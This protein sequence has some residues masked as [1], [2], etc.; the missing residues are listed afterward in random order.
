MTVAVVF[1]LAVEDGLQPV[2]GAAP[3]E[4]LARQLPRLLVAT[5]NGAGDRGVRFLPF[6]GN[7]A[8]K[9]SFLKLQQPLPV[10]TLASLHRQGEV[11]ALVDGQLRQQQLHLRIHDAA[12][13]RPL[14][15]AMLPF[16]PCRPLEVLPRIQFE[17]MSAL[18][19]PGRPPA[20]TTLAGEAQAW[21]LI[22]KDELL[23]LE[24]NLLLNTA[25]DPL[26]A[27][28][29]CVALAG[30]DVD[31]QN[32]VVD[33]SVQLLRHGLQ[34]QGVAALIQ[35]LATLTPDAMPLQQRLAEL[36]QACG[37]EARAATLFARVA[38]ADPANA[39]VVEKAAALLFRS[40]MLAEAKAVL[41]AAHA[42]GSISIAALA[43]LAAI[44]DRLGEVAERDRLGGEL[45]Q[46]GPLPEPVARVLI[47]FLLD[48]GRSIEAL[49]IADQA[50]QLAPASAAMHVERGRALL[51]LDRQ[52]DAVA[53]LQTA[54]EHEPGPELRRECERML[55]LCTA[56]GL[57]PS[58]HRIEHEL[59]HGNTRAA[60]QLARRQVRAVA[61]A[62]EAWLVLGI[63]RQKL[64]QP[65]RAER[66]LR[67]ALA[68]QPDL[69]EAHNR[70]GIL[71]VGRGSCEVGHQHLLRAHQLAPNDPS[72]RLHLAQACVL[73]GRRAEGEDHLLAA[74]RL[75]ASPATLAAV[76]REFFAAGS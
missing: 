4:V 49:T 20:A 76:R 58:L 30:H 37:E 32:V 72:P 27:A 73:L 18:A 52:A 12:Q 3:Y 48:A 50:L 36:L 14:F 55:R 1:G 38:L 60:L 57:L 8:G 21:Y 66:A 11:R 7:D 25:A 59:R 10:E 16:D 61:D 54:L 26:R 34:R 22:A 29:Q 13:L 71:L 5:L 69:A 56:P 19:W 31:V 62:A 51:L 75:G 43:Q 53:A 40:D 70:L 24:A 15:D 44:H 41:Q 33:L 45:Q 17:I 63:V 28:R 2:V 35:Q 6:L 46:R 64:A 39:A 65:R 74:E 47:T 9:R 67:R 68:L 42:A 23:A